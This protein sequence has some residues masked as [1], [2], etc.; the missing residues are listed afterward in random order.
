MGALQRTDF[1]E[2]LEQEVEPKAA[3]AELEAEASS[4]VSSM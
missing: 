3:A 1:P 4:S 2:M